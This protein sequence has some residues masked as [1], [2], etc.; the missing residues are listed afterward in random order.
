MSIEKIIDIQNVGRFEK[1]K[2][3]GNL[4][5]RK[6]TFVFGENGWGKSTLADILRSLG[7]NQAELIQG[8]ET[9]SSGGE[10]KVILL[11]DGKQ[12]VFDGSK[13]KGLGHHI[14]VYDQTFI[15]ENVYSGDLV[16]HDH[17]KNQY[18]LVVGAN[19]VSIFRQIQEID[20]KLRTLNQETKLRESQ[21]ASIASAFGLTDMT[22]VEFVDL[23]QQ[24]NIDA[25]IEAKKLELN[26]A[27][28][29]SQL[30]LAALPEPLPNPITAE[31][32]STTLTFTIDGVAKDAHTRIRK[33][34]S[35]HQDSSASPSIPHESWLEL[36]LDFDNSMSCSFCG[37]ELDDRRLVEAYSDFFS[38]TYKTHAADV[39]QRRQTLNRYLKGDYRQSITTRIA[40]NNTALATVANLTGEKFNLPFD[41]ENACGQIETT[42]AQIDTIFEAKQQDLVTSIPADQFENELRI[43]GKISSKILEYDRNVQTICDRIESIRQAQE[44][45]DVSNLKRELSILETTKKRYE[46]DTIK[47]VSERKDLLD[48]NA[49]L[50]KKKNKLKANLTEHTLRVTEGLGAVINAYLKRLGAGFRIDYQQPN[51]RGKEP[52]AAYNILINETPIPPRSD[53]IGKPSFKNTLSTG[54]KS[55][56]SL[57]LFLATVNSSPILE[58]TIIVLDDPFTSMDE[59][60]RTFTANEISKLT[61]RAK[62][63]IVLSHEKNFIRLLWDRIDHSITSCIAIQTGAPGMA[64]LAQLNIEEATRPRNQTDR[65]KVLQFIDATEGDPG[66]V[67]SLLRPV[68]EHFYRNGDPELFSA[69]EM[70]D[71]IIRKIDA[72]EDD[73]RYKAALSDLKEI[74]QY[75]RNFHHAPVPGS[76]SEETPVEELK[77]YCERVREL[78]RGG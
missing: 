22:A 33:H 16:S 46:V 26:L 53:D 38:A 12:S 24:D 66:V 5:L 57:A 40:A 68:L 54:D 77:V 28:E 1:L 36:G 50:I 9:L 67:R 30:N 49:L 13:W 2:T 55:V 41:I 39:R 63:V 19:G 6:A 73:Y 34:I 69:D 64:S 75:T 27:S 65:T 62:Q 78:T 72:A 7:R 32:L 42:A 48:E 15:N 14:A 59:F 43:W 11:V 52:A 35:Q 70:L 3:P 4:Q 74:N 25:N 47:L 17:L 37:Q 20:K 58:H 71:G 45:A 56:L 18:G 10:Q 23:P 31:E 29:K 76:A 61:D 60:R 21:L 44:E 51:F 8:R